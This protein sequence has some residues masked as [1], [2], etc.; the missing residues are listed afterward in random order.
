MARVLVLRHGQSTWNAESRWQGWADAPLSEAGWSQASAM[1]TQ[2]AAGTDRF[3]K[4]VSSDLSRAVDTARVVAETLQLGEVAIDTSF[5]E[6][7]VGDWCGR[8]TEEIDLI[9][10]G[11]IAAWRSGRLDRP[12]GGEHEPEFRARVVRAVERLAAEDDGPVLV[13]THGG[14]IRSLVRQLGGEPPSTNNLSGWW[15]EMGDDG[16][17]RAGGAVSLASVPDE[18]I[19][20]A[21]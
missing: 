21:L 11:A 10:P 2:L 3:T 5:R 9:W 12:P 18:T 17:L 13:I 6:R 7:D 16:R 15:F 19:T 8:T 20:S 4:V 14:V 1:A